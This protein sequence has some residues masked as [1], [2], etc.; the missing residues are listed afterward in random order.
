[1]G[2]STGSEGFLSLVLILRVQDQG[3]SGSAGRR[4]IERLGFNTTGA[5]YATH[6]GEGASDRK[7]GA[8]LHSGNIF[9]I[10]YDV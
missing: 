7:G 9:W 8:V 10:G 6:C 2:Q 1:V 3:N 4:T 5:V